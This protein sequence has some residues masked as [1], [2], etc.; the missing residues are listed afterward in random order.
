MKG[1]WDILDWKGTKMLNTHENKGSKIYLE[2]AFEDDDTKDVLN[3][4]ILKSNIDFKLFIIGDTAHKVESRIK[5][6]YI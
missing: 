4:W 5:R 1:S 2:S 3:D 6:S